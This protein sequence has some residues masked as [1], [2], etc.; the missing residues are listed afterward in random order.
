MISTICVILALKYTHHHWS[1]THWHSAA[2][3]F[4]D[5]TYRN[6]QHTHIVE[7]TNLIIHRKPNIYEQCKSK[8]NI[9]GTLK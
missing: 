4:G 2:H 3:I 8:C 5:R 1:V 6:G 9:L 7:A